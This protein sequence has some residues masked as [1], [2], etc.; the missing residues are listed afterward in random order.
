MSPMHAEWTL[1]FREDG[2]PQDFLLVSS[3]NYLSSKGCE[4]PPKTENKGRPSFFFQFSFPFLYIDESRVSRTVNAK[5]P[6][7][8]R[9]RKL[10]KG[11]FKC[12]GQM[13]GLLG[14]SS[15]GRVLLQDC[16]GK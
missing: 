2:L 3:H 4:W 14:L 12:Q 13:G 15:T 7:L 9:R 1:F 6:I 8:W 5:A 10:N 16:C 11:R